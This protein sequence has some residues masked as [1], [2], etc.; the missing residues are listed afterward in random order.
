MAGGEP[1]WAYPE[2]KEADAERERLVSAFTRAAAE[3]GYR[4]LTVEQVARDAGLAPDRVG[5]HFSSKEQGMVAAQDVFLNELWLEIVAAC[6]VPADWPA[7]VRA[8][9][10]GAIAF[11]AEVSTLARACAIEAA[12]A[13]AAAADRQ[14]TALERFAF[15]L[16]DG[17]RRYP[18]AAALPETTER[19]LIGGVASIICSC[20]LAEDPAALV[21]LEPQLLELLLTP[22]LGEAEARQVAWAP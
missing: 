2:L 10:R 9:L 8:G 7:K 5:A 11:L 6:Q 19:V 16:R 1:G 14:F 17:R 12:A 20:L 22:Y 3:R 13:S 21:A 4:N 15:L 18:R